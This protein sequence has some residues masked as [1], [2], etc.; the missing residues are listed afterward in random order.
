MAVFLSYFCYSCRIWICLICE[1]C[2]IY[3]VIFQFNTVNN[4]Y[5]IKQYNNK[6]DL[7]LLEMLTEMS[8]SCFPSRP[9]SNIINRLKHHLGIL[10]MDVLQGPDLRIPSEKNPNLWKCL[11]RVLASG[12][13]SNAEASADT[14]DASRYPGV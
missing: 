3:S 2:I 12:T 7:I 1:V 8:F 4:L 14:F 11:S 13:L 10:K 5:C 9:V 6:C